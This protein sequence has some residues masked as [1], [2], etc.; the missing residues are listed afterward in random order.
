MTFRIPLMG[1]LGQTF[2]ENP[3]QY[4]VSW[5]LAG[6]GPKIAGLAF[7]GTTLAILA[8]IIHVSYRRGEA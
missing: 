4:N 6:Y 2:Y 8:A 5:L 7:V 1:E 3:I